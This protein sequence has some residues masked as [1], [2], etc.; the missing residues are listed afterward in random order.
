MLLVLL[1]LAALC[2]GAMPPEPTI[3]C[4]S[5]PGLSPEWMVRHALTPGDLRDLRVE[6]LMATVNV[7]CHEAGRLSSVGW[8]HK[9]H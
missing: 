9:K 2:W 1:S 7:N 3:Q 6:P 4:G 5:E 8:P